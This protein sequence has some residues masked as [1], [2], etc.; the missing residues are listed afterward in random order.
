MHVKYKK[1]WESVPARFINKDMVLSAS[2]GAAFVLVET[3][4]WGQRCDEPLQI[5]YASMFQVSN[6]WQI[7]LCMVK[8]LQCIQQSLL[9]QT[10]CYSM[11]PDGLK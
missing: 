11:N 4:L 1:I 10:V 3:N 9:E 6:S 5:V 7:I 8:N 2:S